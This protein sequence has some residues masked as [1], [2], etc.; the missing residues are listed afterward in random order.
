MAEETIEYRPRI[1]TSDLAA[2][3]QEVRNQINNAVA[4][5]TFS[6]SV[7]A[8][9]PQ[10]F[11]FPLDNA[12]G[13]ATG[14]A[15]NFGNSLQNA[16][17]NG[18]SATQNT[19]NATRL[20]F[21]KFVGDAQNNMLTAGYQNRFMGDASFPIFN[22]DSFYTNWAA[23]TFGY[24]YDPKSSITPGRYKE[25]A[26]EALAEGNL[27]NNFNL[28]GT[29][30]GGLIGS[31][32]G[33]MGTVTGATIGGMVSDFGYD[34]TEATIGRDYASAKNLRNYGRETSWRFL[35]GRLDR[36]DLGK[37]ALDSVRLSRDVST[38]GYD[39]SKT[40]IERLTKEYTEIGGFDFVRTAEEYGKKIKTVVENHRKVMQVLRMSE[41]DAL[42]TMKSLDQFGI[43][44][45]SNATGIAA[46]AYSAGYTP[47]EFLQFAGQSAEMVRGTGINMGSAFL[48]G[49]TALSM[50]K[51]GM[52]EGIT[53][54]T[55]V[56]QSGG[57]ENM[58]LTTQR[59]G[60]E[61]ANSMSGFTQLVA[62][63]AMGGPTK[64][65]GLG[66]V[67]TLATAVGAL[68]AGGVQGILETQGSMPERIS[69]Y[70]AAGL[71]A[72]S[73]SQWIKQMQMMG[74][75]VNQASLRGYFVQNGKS[76]LEAD[77]VWNLFQVNEHN[78]KQG[79]K[80]Y[81][82]IAQETMNQAIAA[83]PTRWD[84]TMDS[85]KSTI[86]GMFDWS[87]DSMMS[88]EDKAFKDKAATITEKSQGMFKLD[89][90]GKVRQTFGW[91]KEELDRERAKFGKAGSKK[92]DYELSVAAAKSAAKSAKIEADAEGSHLGALL[93]TKQAQDINLMDVMGVKN[94]TD[95]G[96]KFSELSDGDIE[97]LAVKYYQGVGVDEIPAINKAKNEI[98]PLVKQLRETYAKEV[99]VTQKAYSYADRATKVIDSGGK[100]HK[101]TFYEALVDVEDTVASTSLDAIMPGAS[102]VY[103]LFNRGTKTKAAR[104]ESLKN[105]D[106]AAE[107]SGTGVQAMKKQMAEIAEIRKGLGD[108]SFDSKAMMGGRGASDEVMGQI[109]AK[110]AQYTETNTRRTAD[111]IEKLLKEGIRAKLF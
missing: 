18:M 2:Q 23:T 67:D 26:A 64:A 76:T 32:W 89:T 39:I 9:Q 109:N 10:M 80:L 3:L 95:L 86:S 111:G 85:I 55:L 7:P 69:Q 40:D 72:Y 33:P 11:A 110:L 44:A 99:K 56:S 4:Q 60:Y 91:S 90:D 93:L 105:I 30:I 74:L 108:I 92:T 101:D 6:T 48:S 51:Y 12:M 106:T 79:S 88:A 61:W 31:L 68:T 84:V 46:M 13:M 66:V 77:N 29:G 71:A 83:A 104:A 22:P 81:D 87:S 107:A 53:P 50:L 78:A 17:I 57:L 36:E 102:I 37:V 96:K 52:Q 24:G 58:T 54:L 35:S 59:T 75:T 103:N 94:E 82:K 14:D 98:K 97:R 47:K 43:D 16:T 42:Q 21:Q 63:A 5:Q 25:R 20:G 70:S 45:G 15:R 38:Q 28:F 1:D 65:A 19:I 27:K 8:P 100:A 34:A 49:M 73:G 41:Q 62:D